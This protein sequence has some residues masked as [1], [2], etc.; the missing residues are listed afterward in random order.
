M[1]EVDLA[2]AVKARGEFKKTEVTIGYGAHYGY[3]TGLHDKFT[4]HSQFPCGACKGQATING[5]T[6]RK[7]EGTGKKS[8]EKVA[9]RYAIRNST[10]AFVVQ[11]EWVN[12]S[13]SEPGTLKDGSPKSPSTLWIRMRAISE[14]KSTESEI[15]AWFAELPRPI[16]VPVEVMVTDNAK[17]DAHIIASVRRFHPKPKSEQPPKVEPE[18]D[19]G[20]DFD[21]P[22]ERF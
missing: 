5:E 4:E 2:G 13:L 11:D 15:M 10:G 19:G 21:D 18:F 20:M 12:Y 9:I 1:A 7:C 22:G 3:F 17:G 6:C 8:T 14:G 16:K